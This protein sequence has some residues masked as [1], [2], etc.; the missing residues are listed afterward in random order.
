LQHRQLH[1]QRKNHGWAESL[2][3]KLIA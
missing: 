3:T 2:E 1:R